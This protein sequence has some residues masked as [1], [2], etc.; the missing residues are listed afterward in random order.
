M[1]SARVRLGAR[2]AGVPLLLLWGVLAALLGGGPSSARGAAPP[3]PN[4]GR[5]Y[6]AN[7]TPTSALLAAYLNPRG[8][9]TSFFFQYGP[10]AA[11]GNQTPLTGIGSGSALVYVQQQLAGLAPHTVYHFRLVA[12]SAGGVARSSDRSFTTPKVPLSLQIAAEPDPL[13]F[14]SAFLVRGTLSGTGAAGHEV[15]LQMSPYPYTAPMRAIANAELTDAAGRFSFPVMSLSEN[16]RFR[17]VALGGGP[18]VYSPIVLEGVSV[19]VVL[20]VVRVRHRRGYYRLY[21]TVQ[22]AEPGAHVGF[23]LLRRHGRS[24]NVGGA[25][26]KPYRASV[27]RFS[28]V[29]RLRHHRIYEALVKIEDPARLSGYSEPVRIR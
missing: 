24:I 18:A 23:Q 10:T 16:A 27:S 17:V 11:Y 15:V 2:T 1:T 9:A 25:I 19:H 4:L 29:M 14:G 28:H 7:V 13:L 22:P 3:P 6:A 26:V 12:V 5:V 20:H 21:G 8:Q